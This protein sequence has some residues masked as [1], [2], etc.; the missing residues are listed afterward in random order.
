MV[1]SKRGGHQGYMFLH[2]F[3]NQKPVSLP[4][5]GLLCTL[6]VSQELQD[7]VGQTIGAGVDLTGQVVRAAAPVAQGVIAAVRNY[8]IITLV[9]SFCRYKT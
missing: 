1:D 4:Q 9:I 2:V 6:V 5:P 8:I 3:D 7:T